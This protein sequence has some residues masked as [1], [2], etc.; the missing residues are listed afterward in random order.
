MFWGGSFLSA[1][2]VIFASTIDIE[3]ER[4]MIFIG[5]VMIISVI[6]YVHHEITNHLLGPN[7]SEFKVGIMKD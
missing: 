2:L 5:L 3:W 7:N 1:Y 6:G 4:M